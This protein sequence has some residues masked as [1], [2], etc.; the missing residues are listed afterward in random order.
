[1][2]IRAADGRN[3]LKRD[4]RLYDVIEMD[5]LGLSR[6]R[7]VADL[8]A[9]GKRLFQDARGYVTT[10]VNGTPITENGV[11]TGERPGRLVRAS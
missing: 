4:K 2:R 11:L 6:P 3:A 5:A 1:M 8:P 10:M 7:L 9:G